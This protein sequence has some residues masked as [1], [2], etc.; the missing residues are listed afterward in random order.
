[1]DCST[2]CHCP[3][4]SPRVWLLGFFYLFVTCMWHF[5][6]MCV[7]KHPWKRKPC[8]N[9][10]TSNSSVRF[11]RSFLLPFFVS[12]FEVFMLDVVM[13][14]RGD[15]KYGPL[16]LSSTWKHVWVCVL[17]SVCLCECVLWHLFETAYSC[18][19]PP[20]PVCVLK[21]C[22]QAGVAYPRTLCFSCVCFAKLVGMSGAAE[23]EALV[24][25]VLIWHE[26]AWLP[27]LSLPLL[28]HLS[29]GW[30]HFVVI[31]RGTGASAP[32]AWSWAHALIGWL[33][34]FF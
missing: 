7:K 4:S 28:L 22:S 32:R 6:W 18:T 20:P 17:M 27:S 21:C 8:F 26:G 29:L 14:L 31:M 23:Q 19:P 30:L 25:A 9:L 33:L 3:V 13:A 1:M 34:F 15:F 5:T 11:F 10:T 12:F 2:C 16:M 24:S